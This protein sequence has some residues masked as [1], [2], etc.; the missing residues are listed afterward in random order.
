MDWRSCKNLRPSTY[1]I[2]NVQQFGRLGIGFL[3]RLDIALQ[4]ALQFQVLVLQL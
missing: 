2:K 4:L 3:P 1:L